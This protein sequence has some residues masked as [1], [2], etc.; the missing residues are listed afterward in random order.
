MQEQKPDYFKLAKPLEGNPLV[1]RFA[2]LAKELGVVLPSEWAAA[3]RG[4]LFQ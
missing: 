2:A 3:G 4:V 1:Q